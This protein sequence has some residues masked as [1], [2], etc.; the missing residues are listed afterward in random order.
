M[1]GTITALVGC[2][3]TACATEVSHHLDMVRMYKGQPICEEC[4]DDINWNPPGDVV[5][6]W[7]DL[8]EISLGDLK[9]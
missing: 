8:P 3:V 2:Q 5:P 9:I 7:F 4:Y 1:V 6:D